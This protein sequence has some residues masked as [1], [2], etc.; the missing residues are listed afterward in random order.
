[1]TDNT[2]SNPPEWVKDAVFYQIF[3]DR[4]AISTSLPKPCRLQ[5]WSSAPTHHGYKG[6][7]LLGIAEHLDYLQDLGVNALYLNPVFQ[8]T[9][10]HRY[11]TYDYFKV[12]PLLGGNEALQTLIEASHASGIRIV[13]D[14]VFNHTGRG[15]FQFNDIL[16]NGLDSPYLDWFIIK[17]HPIDAYTNAHAVNYDAWWNLPALP[18]LNVGNPK[19]R[20]FIWGIAEYWIE[21]GIDGWRL[22]VPEEIQFPG[23][24]EEFRRRVKRANPDAYILGEI[25]HDA[26]DWLTGD[27]FDAVMNYPFSRACLGFFGGDRLDVSARPGGH[28]LS[29]LDVHGFAEEIDRLLSQYDLTHSQ[30][31]LNLLGSHDTSRFLTLV[32][33]DVER[34]KLAVFFQMTFVGAPCTYY[35]DEIGLTGGPDPDNRRAMIWDQTQWNTDLHDYVARC[36]MLRRHNSALRRGDYTRLY[37]ADGVL[38][39]GRR[40]NIQTVISVINNGSSTFAGSIPLR[41]YAQEGLRFEDALNGG[42]SP[43]VANGC[44]VGQRLAPRSASAYVSKSLTHNAS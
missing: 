25:W 18:K 19:V 1:M 8:S 7:D 44:L 3:P 42:D 33:G 13:L 35:G 41:D 34:F 12:D 6:G 16:E 37:S 29:V 5:P 24:W 15:F 17:G 21:Q 4:F 10:N 39:F 31:Q 32:S 43:V 38:A 36:T 27:R 11:H 28:S 30:V 40:D 9:A 14:G 23:F 26:P 20:E 2:P 22:D